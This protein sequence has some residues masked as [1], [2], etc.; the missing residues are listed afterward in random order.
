LDNKLNIFEGIQRNWFFIVINVIMVGGQILIIFVGGQAFHVT[1]LNGAQ[2]GYSIVLGALS[3]PVAVIIRLIPDRYIAELVPRVWRRKLV[4]EIV[5][6]EEARGRRE[7]R[8]EH[9]AF[10]KTIR[11]GRV[12]SLQF[13][14]DAV[15]H[16]SG[17]NDRMMGAI[18]GASN[19]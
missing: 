8:P 10:M 5:A 2:W 12:S 13:K 14:L 19:Y 9:L 3:L 17:Y 15:K 18:T 16:H 1:P 7:S 11:G 4:P 6:E